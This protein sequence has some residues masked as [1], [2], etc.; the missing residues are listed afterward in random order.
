MY[1]TR[2]AP[3]PTGAMHLGHAR[4]AL[5]TWLRARS[6]GGRILMRVEDL[7]PPRVK[8]GSADAILRDHAWLGLD[9]D[10]GPVFQ[11]ARTD[12]YEAALTQLTQAGRTFPCTCTRR[13][14]EAAVSSAPHAGELDGELVYPG[15][16]R[17]RLT[18]APSSSNVAQQRP[19]LS[20]RGAR[21]PAVRFALSEA[22]QRLA[23]FTD[24][25]Q[26]PVHYPLGGDF[27]IKR[28]DG[29][30]AYQLAVVV[31][32]AELGVTEVVRGDDL[33]SS[34]PRQLALYAALGHAAPQFAHL[35]LVLDEQGGRLS[36]RFG[37]V[38]VTEY[39]DAGVSPERMLGWLGR[40]L[41]QLDTAAPTTLSELLARFDVTRVPRGAVTAP[42]AL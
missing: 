15:T 3:S 31:D 17:R 21:P 13:E 41:G 25:L 20:P 1:K 22:D 5:L 38:G 26:G 9:W 8:A 35:G 4:T 10:E 28:S 18:A 11:S 37:S 36:K 27:V 14:I 24:L 42:A 30:F 6:L 2:Y 40:S 33:L 23:H 19:A 39:A 7:D 29:L 34:T 16:C 32:D 12:A